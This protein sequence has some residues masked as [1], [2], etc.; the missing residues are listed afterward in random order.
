MRALILASGRGSRLEEITEKQPKG[1]TL[2]AG[3]TL[4]DWQ[5]SAL[6]KA[7]VSEIGV[8][9]G[10]YSDIFRD[11]FE[12]R[13]H[14]ANWRNSNMVSSLLCARE[15]VKNRGVIVSY[16]DIIYSPNSV[17]QLVNCK[18]DIAIAYDPNWLEQWSLRYENPF[19]DAESFSQ[20]NG[21]LI[22]IGRRVH[23]IS[24]INGQYMGLIKFSAKGWELFESFI[25]QYREAEID[26]FDMTQVL[27]MMNKSG[28]TIHTIATSDEWVEVDT[29]QDLLIAQQRMPSFSWYESQ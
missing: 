19:D 6:K 24:E 22:D 4:I 21:I 17:Q 5:V 16:S 12:H 10:Y 27:Q 13:F 7:A 8:T 15:F 23:T 29:K 3:K 25:A 2:V 20:K 11:Y 26:K 1:L 18:H 28:I 9:T 14:N